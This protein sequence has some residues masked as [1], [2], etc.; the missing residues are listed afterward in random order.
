MA[1]KT[2]GGFGGGEK[3]IM[4]GFPSPKIPVVVKICGAKQ[5]SKLESLGLFYLN[6]KDYTRRLEETQGALY[7]CIRIAL[8]G[9]V[10]R[11]YI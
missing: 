8:P 10:Y 5:E 11:H 4:Q 6:I 1:R 7:T 2:K 9:W 3:C